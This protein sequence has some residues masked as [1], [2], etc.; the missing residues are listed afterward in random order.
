M[1]DFFK[2]W[3][4][5]VGVAT[6]VIACCI[7]C[8]WGA[9]HNFHIPSIEWMHEHPV[10][11]RDGEIL[12]QKITFIHKDGSLLP[13]IKVESETT[14]SLL[15]VAAPLT[16]LSAYLLLSKPQKPK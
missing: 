16:L 13:F 10:S 11:L 15:T 8:L 9:S 6:L 5:S 14:V 1:G 12:F 7:L 4:R 2:P 3:R